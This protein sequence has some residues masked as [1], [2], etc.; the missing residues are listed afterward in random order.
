MEKAPGDEQGGD[1]QE[2]P[3]HPKQPLTD[4]AGE[5]TKKLKHLFLFSHSVS[6]SLPGEDSLLCVSLLD[7]PGTCWSLGF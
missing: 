3:T 5:P 6:E 4:R 7:L 2:G 1:S